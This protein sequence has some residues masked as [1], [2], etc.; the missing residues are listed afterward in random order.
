VN[1]YLPVML[2]IIALVTI[3]SVPSL[4]WK[5]CP[6]CG[7]RNILD[8]VTCQVCGAPFPEEDETNGRSG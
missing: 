7:R 2:G 8:A 1:W 6:S 4:F 5:K 3:V